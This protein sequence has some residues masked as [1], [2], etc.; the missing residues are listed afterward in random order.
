MQIAETKQNRNTTSTKEIVRRP[1][2]FQP[3]L[4]I[5]QPSDVY[6]QEADAMADKV[7]QEA[8]PEKKFFPP[9]LLQRR[10]AN[11]EDEVIE[12]KLQKK[13]MN[14]KDSIIQRQGDEAPEN[15]TPVSHSPLF[16]SLQLPL[17]VPPHLD[18]PFSSIDYLSLHETFF[19]RGVMFSGSYMEDAQ[20]EW[21][22]Q[23]LFYRGF[24]LGNV[25]GNT[26]LGNALR[27]FGA[28]PPGGDWNAW[29]SNITTPLSVDSALSRDYP[30]LNEQQER[31]GGLPSPTIVHLPEVHF[32]K[33]TGDGNNIGEVSLKTE[34][35]LSTLSGGEALRERDEN[36]FGER[37][38]SDFSKVKIHRDSAANE[39]AKSLNALAYT[40][41]N[42]IVFASGQY[43]PETQEGKRLLA[44]ELTHVVQQ[45]GNNTAPMQRKPSPGAHNTIQTYNE[46]SVILEDELLDQAA[47]GLYPGM[48]QRGYYKVELLHLPPEAVELMKPVEIKPLQ[49]HNSDTIPDIESPGSPIHPIPPETRP[50]GG[51]KPA[52]SAEAI[53]VRVTRRIDIKTNRG[54]VA[55][56][57]MIAQTSLSKKFVITK[58]TPREIADEL[59]NYVFGSA[60][61]QILFN[62]TFPN[63]LPD[64]ADPV[65]ETKVTALNDIIRTYAP[66]L[67]G[68]DLPAQRQYDAAINLLLSNVPYSAIVLDDPNRKEKDRE[69][70]TLDEAKKAAS[71][72]GRKDLLIV[73]SQDGK[74]H[75]HEMSQ[76]DL[77]RMADE[78]RGNDNDKHKIDWHTA[79]NK[80]KVEVLYINGKETDL[81]SVI[82]NAYYP[83]REAAALGHGK[84]SDSEAVVYRM[85]SS[86]LY[87]RKPIAHDDAL[88]IWKVI[89][90]KIE[91]SDHI[92]KAFDIPGGKFIALRAKGTGSFHTI[93]ADYVEGKRIYRNSKED[94]NKEG[95]INAPNGKAYSVFQ[96]DMFQN[97][98][99]Q[100][101]RKYIDAQLDHGAGKDYLLR[102][103]LK[104][105]NHLQNEI[106]DYVLDSMDSQ[107][108]VLAMDVL[109]KTNGALKAMSGTDDSMRNLILSLPSMTPKDRIDVLSMMGVKEDYKPFYE[110]VLADNQKA[111]QIAFGVPVQGVSFQSLRNGMETVIKDTD[112][113]IQQINDFSLFPLRI[114]GDF[115]NTIREKVYNDN[116]FTKIKAN[117]YP[118]HDE[119]KS[120]F[121]EPLEGN[122]YDFSGL[123]EQIYANKVA[124]MDHQSFVLKIPGITLLAIVTAAIVVFSGG[125]GAGVAAAFFEAGT[126]SFVATEIVVGAATMTV[127]G[128]GLNQVLGQGALGRDKDY[129]GLGE[130]FKSF[131]EN[132][133]LSGIFAG[134]GRIM[135]NAASIWRLSATGTLFLGYSLGKY[136]YDNKKLPQGRDLYT[137]IYQN[138]V[139]LA[140]IEAGGILSRPLTKMFYAKGLDARVSSINAKITELRFDI[141]TSQQKLAEMVASGKLNDAEL[142]QHISGQRTLLERQQ[143]ILIELRD[144]K[145][146]KTDIDVNDELKNVEEALQKIRVVEFQRKINF[147]QNRF[148]PE[149]ISYTAGKASVDEIIKFYGKDNVT[150]PDEK[151]IIKVNTPDGGEI[152][153]YPDN[154]ETEVNKSILE[155]PAVKLDNK[156]EHSI[157]TYWKNID[158]IPGIKIFKGEEV[159][160]ALDFW[161]EKGDTLF[162]IVY[163]G[164]FYVK[165]D[166][167][168]GRLLIGDI[169]KG[170]II[171][172][173]LDDA[174]NY[175]KLPHSEILIKNPVTDMPAAIEKLLLYHG[176][177]EPTS[178]PAPLKGSFSSGASIVATLDKTTTIVG[179]FTMTEGKITYTDM[180]QLFDNFGNLKNADFGAKPGGFNVLNVGE[181]FYQPGTFF[182]NYNRPWLETAIARGDKFYSASD[183]QNEKFIYERDKISDKWVMVDDP[184]TGE[185]VRKKTGFGKEVQILEE[186]GYKYD[187]ATKM[188][189][190]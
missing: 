72:L 65:N 135:K 3:K 108:R 70:K 99:S 102:D 187:P 13:E 15:K 119:T 9:A 51:S 184:V 11:Y 165:Y 178:S 148:A 98:G 137:F 4:T 50:I 45:R 88:A 78:L 164:R 91:F 79:P 129:Y 93:D 87:A 130:L 28:K 100:K 29:L 42:D 10:D 77:M 14:K 43:Q 5:N 131:G 117:T 38:D 103:T 176:L 121:P 124:N 120:F 48:L 143:K 166:A 52:K 22:R 26:F 53:V 68:Y 17:L 81:T 160:T 151:G 86:G 112:K 27:T 55:H 174:R 36:Y 69:Y 109:N 35:Y 175:P 139:T 190:K 6:E 23:Y 32:K 21:A 60:S 89:D 180:P 150:G 59:L 113:L 126:A 49:I 171:G 83:D 115:G 134:V 110:K 1:L 153:F 172:F 173:Y 84:D 123:M 34:N 56:I 96:Y 7:M 73:Q 8:P 12:K 24:G 64:S 145:E 76:M 161:H 95:Q 142:F 167:K 94:Y 37:L 57:I 90:D 147:R 163:K 149:K 75:I 170:E 39:S 146:I 122:E 40:K 156:T 157:N 30:N 33:A 92:D 188:Y 46:D 111:A 82:D 179:A 116:G 136:Y 74:Y 158:N 168:N 127:L 133:L 101:L 44:H 183:P 66:D 67:V 41:G 152:E 182:E 71:A 2:F 141:T 54:V 61:I 19:N 169:N 97:T 85:N 132:L 128:E 80:E 63:Q 144:A 162:D 155:K 62:T 18:P 106:S 118:H 138:L 189:T 25:I 47:G 105:K 185:K 177:V 154:L 31:Q 181:G 125:V 140:A 159:V 114:E 20:K 58:T 186:H 16:K 104:G 107:A